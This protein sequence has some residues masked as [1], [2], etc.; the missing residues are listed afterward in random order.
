MQA[1]RVAGVPRWS[2]VLA[3]PVEAALVSRR[4]VVVVLLGRARR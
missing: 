4:A 1:W 3:M 2:A